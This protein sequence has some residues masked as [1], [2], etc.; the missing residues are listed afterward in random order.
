MTSPCDVSPQQ[1]AAPGPRDGLNHMNRRRFLNRGVTAA[2]TLT[3]ADFLGYFLDHGCPY[4]SRRMAMAE[5]ADARNDDPHFLIYWFVEGGW[6]GYSMFNP[7][8]TPNNV[9]ERLDN[10]SAERYRVLNFGKEKYGIYD[11]G[12]IHFGYL[13][14]EGKSL[15][16][17]MAIVSSMHVATFHSGQRL[18]AH[19]GDPDLRPQADREDDERSVMQAFAEVYGHPYLL[20]HLSWHW[21][22]SDGELN[23]AQYTGRKGYYHALGP[24]HAHTIY[25]GTPGTLKK[26]LRQTQAS[27]DDV[28]SRK[29]QAFLDGPNSQLTKDSELTVVKSYNSAVQIYKNLAKSGY[30]I[31]RSLLGRLFTN[32]D[33]R[34]EFE[35]QPSDEQLSYR[36]VNG[37]KARTKFSP[38][39]NVQA[40]MTYEL[41]RAGLSCAFWIETRDIRMFDS[42]YTRGALWKGGSPRGQRDQTEIMS[43]HL[44]TP[45]I[46]LVDKL[47][48]T[49]YRN[50]GKSLYDLTNIVLT[51]EFGRSIHGNVNAILNSELAEDE[52][53]EK[54][55]S[56][57]ISAH[58]KVTSAAFLGGDVKGNAQYGK[59]GEKTLMAIPILPDGSLDPAYDLVSGELKPDCE[60]SPKSFIPGHGDVYATALYLSDINPQG[61]GR[62]K[63]PPLQFISNA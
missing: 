18:I 6:Q 31:D 5:D 41:I 40:M 22:L 37:H 3:A 4:H 57:D 17:D 16:P 24:V 7:V 42:H 50:T 47:K 21:W 34:A 28:V 33:L 15:F 54:I 39:V 43:T 20:P 60:K 36:S 49:Q 29:I 11:E 38:N 55:D 53:K 63:R 12:N 26:F 27:A 45:L 44:W 10:P 19:M 25:A 46:T 56:Q 62:N 1:H 51:S 61:I 30:K 35:V 8:M 13:A 23:E 48:N 52:K 2:A 59:I 58:W 9:H 14:S 32:A